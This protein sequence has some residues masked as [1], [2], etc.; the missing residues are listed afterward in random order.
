MPRNGSIQPVPFSQVH[1]H[2]AFW[3]PRLET[4]RRVTIP[5]DFE[6]CEQTGR[7]RNFDLAAG[8]DS[9]VHTGRRYDDSD[10]FK[11][12]E[13]AA[14]SLSQHPDAELEQYLD[15][16]IARIAA[17]QEPDGYLYTIRTIDPD[18]V[19]IEQVGAT[20][21]SA[22]STSHELYNVGHLYEAAVAYK[23]ATGKR[24]LLDV[25]IKN[26]DLID[27]VFGPDSHRGVPGH[28]EIEIGLVK[29]FRE[30][31]N[32]RYLRLAR[33]F[34]DERGRKPEPDP[35][36]AAYSQNHLPIRQQEEAVG[37][38]VRATY[39]YAAIANI[40]ALYPDGAYKQTLDHIWSDV[41]GRKMHLTGGLGAR[42]DIEGFGPAYH[43]PN[44]DTY[45]ET[46]ASIGSILWNHRMFLLTGKSKYYDVLERT[47]YNGFL[48]GVSLKGDTFFYPN[49][50]ESDGVY[51]FNGGGSEF[52]AA[53]RLPWF[54][55]SCCPTNVARL[56]ASLGDYIYAV[57]ED[58][59]YVNLFISSTVTM[60]VNQH[61]IQIQQ[62]TR[63]PWNGS[64]TL[65][66]IADRPVTFTMRIRYPGWAQGHPV[67][68]DLYKYLNCFDTSPTLRIN[69][70]DASYVLENGYMCVQRTWTPGDTLTVTLPMP[71]RYI[72]SH[73]NVTENTGKIALERGPLVYCVEGVDHAGSVSHLAIQEQ[74][75]LTAEHRPDLLDGV[76]VI[77][78]KSQ[79]LMAIPYYAWS[80][81]GV[82]PMKVWFQQ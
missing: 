45:N 80:H 14:Y 4:N 26:A 34:L 54:S 76:T 60:S 9:G 67:P 25:A 48:S 47:L 81:R 36:Q 68:S 82:G 15:G 10:V 39:M 35:E 6:K 42:R 5:Y 33:F 55:T 53:T 51:A 44:I 12:I 65:T 24:S 50:L 73:D 56:M 28:Q 52:S 40:T 49:P 79:E 66:V 71:V 58:H 27:S 22:L 13:A 63:Y 21:W 31:G 41:V 29:L 2:D 17:A 74:M 75:E 20:R 38:A 3:Q 30:T 32:E 37:H 70:E 64:T 43:L 16:I 46:C 11:V 72:V 19:D 1:I 61:D 69:S 7:I 77:Q 57:R 8:M 23:Q 62:E 78:G 59:M 18:A